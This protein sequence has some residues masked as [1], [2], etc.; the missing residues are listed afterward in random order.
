[1]VHTRHFL[2]PT[3][4]SQDLANTENKISV[5]IFSP[6]PSVSVCFPDR[7]TYSSTVVLL[8]LSWNFAATKENPLSLADL[9]SAIGFNPTRC[10]S[11]LTEIATDIL[12][13]Q[14]AM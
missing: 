2:V 12:K 4:T 10:Y 14:V 1:M 13:R 6:S 8:C 3:A 11:F 7:T 5:A 9:F